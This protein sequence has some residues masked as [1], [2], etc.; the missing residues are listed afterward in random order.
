MAPPRKR[1][2]REIRD[3]YF[4]LLYTHTHTTDTKFINIII[5]RCILH[6][7]ESKAQPSICNGMRFRVRDFIVS[8]ERTI[9]EYLEILIENI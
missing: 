5:V 8:L 4:A 3:F 9:H 7:P 1:T 2:V 6:S